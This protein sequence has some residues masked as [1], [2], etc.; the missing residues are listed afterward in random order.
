M[1]SVA[2]ILFSSDRTAVYLMKRRD[3]PV[4]VL[5]GGGIEKGETAEQAAIR[6]VEEELGFKTAI[7]RKVA[8]YEKSGPFIKP[9][10]FFE[11]TLLEKG[12]PSPQETVEVRLF[13]LNKLPPLIP[14]YREWIED[15][16]ANHPHPLHKQPKSITPWVAC[17]L[18]LSHPILFIR[19]LLARLGLPL[20]TTISKKK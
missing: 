9:T 2:T 14:V 11:C 18:I 12:S 5:P 7:A 17:K 19:F 16:A 10:H 8:F 4:W 1:S 20:N 6:E 15:A 3:V 13:P